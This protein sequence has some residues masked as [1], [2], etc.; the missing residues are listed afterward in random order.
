[1]NEL[2]RIEAEFQQYVLVGDQRI[3]REIAGPDDAYRDTRLGI[4]FDAYRLRLIEVLGK[5]Y[6][7]LKAYVGDAIFERI[8]TTYIDAHPSVFRNVRWLGQ[9]MA[10]HLRAATAITQREVLA[11]LAA[12]EWAL[13][14]A[15][16]AEDVPPLRF[17]QVAT[18]AP[19][20]WASVRFTR[21]PA[22]QILKLTTNA[23]AIWNA[24][25]EEGEAIAPETLAEPLTCIVWRADF[26]A[27]FRSLDPDAAWAI[28]AMVEGKSFPEIC[29]GLC[30]WLPEE[31][32]AARAAALLRGWVDDGWIAELAVVG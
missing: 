17:E 2:A 3:A 22:L 27:Y 9:H 18:L 26:T 8:A 12:F 24:Q 15:F 13:G 1:M 31:A 32:A 25:G 4:Y 29:E 30:Q 14:L 11:D 21:H 7:V 16:D 5:D 20:A 19:D 6:P 28:R 23:L 10:A